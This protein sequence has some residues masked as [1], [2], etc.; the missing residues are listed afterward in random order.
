[1]QWRWSRLVYLCITGQPCLH[2]HTHTHHCWERQYT[3]WMC[4]WTRQTRV[5]FHLHKV[6]DMHYAASCTV[7]T[8]HSGPGHCLTS[9]ITHVS[10]ASM[11]WCLYQALLRLSMLVM[12]FQILIIVGFNQTLQ[13]VSISQPPLRVSIHKHAILWPTF[14]TISPTTTTITWSGFLNDHQRDDLRLDEI[15]FPPFD[16]ERVKTGA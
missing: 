4:S 10:R 15:F 6:S 8:G 3:C 14:I 9:T 12:R 13:A 16:H 1:M 7:H 2:T 11:E 5:T